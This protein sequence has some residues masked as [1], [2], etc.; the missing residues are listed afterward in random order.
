VMSYSYTGWSESW[1]SFSNDFE[2]FCPRIPS[3]Q[4]ILVADTVFRW[5]GATKNGFPQAPWG[6]NHSDMTWPTYG[7]PKIRDVNQAFGDGSV[8]RKRGADFNPVA[9]DALSNDPTQVL[10]ISSATSETKDRRFF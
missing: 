7:A 1:S 9:M 2:R 5:D 4:G 10:F 8:R 3:A 6:V